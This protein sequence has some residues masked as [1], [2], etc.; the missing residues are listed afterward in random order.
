MNNIQNIPT[1]K[2]DCINKLS[3]NIVYDCTPAGRAKSGLET[4]AV[5]LNRADIDVASLTQ[6]GAT[7]SNMNLNSDATG[8]SISWIKQLSTAS[9]EYVSNDS[10]LDT[11]SHKFAARVHGST[12]QD[13]ERIEELKN[14]EIVVV[15]ESKF[16]GTNNTAA[17][18]VFGL[19]QSL[20]MSS[21]TYSSAE[22]DGSFVFEL[23]S[24]EGFGE[25]YPYL[26]YNE[27]TYSATKA[28]VDN[29]FA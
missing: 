11:F 19:E 27:G 25:S 3:G 14:A 15:V 7:V 21:G 16:K 29:L 17:Y 22:N 1:N 28:K 10:G 2:M 12:A 24:Q 26:I 5:F 8:Y 20:K 9:S 18:K 23:A 6:S 13:A 4:K